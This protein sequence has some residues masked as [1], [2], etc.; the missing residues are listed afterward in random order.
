MYY[1]QE[2]VNEITGI[3]P[4]PPICKTL[5]TNLSTDITNTKYISHLYIPSDFL[6][7]LVSSEMRVIFYLEHLCFF[8]ILYF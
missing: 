5:K 8:Y 3:P 2:G 6:G 4:L 7:L 1:I